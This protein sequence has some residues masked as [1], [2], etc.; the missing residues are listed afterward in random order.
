[1]TNHATSSSNEAK[2]KEIYVL[3]VDCIKKQDFA[4]AEKYLTE[5]MSIFPTA[6]AAHNLGTL[7]YMQGN[8]SK[9]VEL[10][11]TAIQLNPH[12]DAAYANLMRIMHQKGDMAKAMEYSALAITAAPE[13]KDHKK[14]F[15]KILALT[16]FE[17]SSPDIKHLIT[18]C[19][20]DGSLNYD[21]I[22]RAWFSL[23]VTD[24]EL[25]PFYSLKKNEDFSSFERQ[26]RK[27]T[28]REFLL[29]R[30]LTLG[31]ENVIVGDLSFERLLTHMRHLLLKD[32]IQDN[33][34]L[35]GI[36]FLPFLAALSVYCFYTEYLFDVSDEEN[37]L[38]EKL[39]N[40]V[41][42]Q[43]DISGNPYPLCL[44][45][46]YENIW[47][48]KASADYLKQLKDSKE[49]QTFVSYH[50]AGPLEEQEIKKAI[51]SITEVETETS[52]EVQ[53]QYEELPYP[54]WRHTPEA[55]SREDTALLQKYL[56]KGKTKLLIAGT[57]TG[58]EASFY[59]QVL[60]ESEILAVDLS[61][62]SLAYGIRKTEEIGIKNIT[63]RQADILG[64]GKV[65]APDSFDLIVSSGVLHHMK[66][67]EDGLAVVTS[68]LKP[69]GVMH[70]A[71][72][73]K[74]ARRAIIKAREIIAKNGIGGDHESMKEFRRNALN[75]LPEEDV[76]SL[77]R[78]RDYYFLSEYKD[79]IFHV[80]EHCY[81]I[82]QISEMLRKN[83]LEFLGFRDIN[84]LH[85]NYSKAFPDD[86]QRTNLD[87]W[88]KFEIANPDIFRRMYQ[89]W[90]RKKP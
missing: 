47:K 71:L 43:E 15:L 89:F 46:C 74:H 77:V 81:D 62:S 69:D 88:N 18:L 80:M 2:A 14:E 75:W 39:K 31:L 56:P 85:Q 78:F 6:D 51:V 26:F 66:V 20:E 38:L 45:A 37:E 42:L 48:H 13:K 54:R 65:L 10:F 76:E 61:K 25:A 34:S 60:P 23:M 32:Y 57:G 5:S 84:N 30:Y 50:L 1:M 27:N 53:E 55:L 21:Y 28:D 82:P 90:V 52:R 3:A 41:A 4:G 17:L 64:L 36:Q 72:Y 73:S 22:G 68:L 33:Q 40:E 8:I 83:N 49:L 35:F 19:F 59:T 58:Q 7:R 63:F 9:A 24:H 86:P 87:N 11:H 79:L 67:P 70:L 29:S 16:K 12:Y 44:L